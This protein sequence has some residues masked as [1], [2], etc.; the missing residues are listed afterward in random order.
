MEWALMASMTVNGL[1]VGFIIGIVKAHQSMQGD[2][3]VQ[4]DV[5]GGGIAQDPDTDYVWE[6]TPMGFKGP[7]GK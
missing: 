7:D 4:N 3:P 1:L 6:S 5:P 2:A